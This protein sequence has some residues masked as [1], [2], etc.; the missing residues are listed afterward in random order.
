MKQKPAGSPA[1]AITVDAKRDECEAATM[2][3]VMVGPYLRHGIVANGIIE[4]MAGKLP[5]EPKFEDFA[6]DIKAKADLAS[7]GEMTLASEILAAQALSLDMLFTEL[8]RRATMNLGDY[9]LMAE[10]YAR[11]AFKAQGNCRAS[12]EALA[13][14]HQ[15]REQTVRHVH[16][17]EGGQA[18]IADEFHHHGGQEKNGNFDEQSHATGTAGQGPSLPSPDPH[19]IGVPIAS[20]QRE[21][22]L[23][24]ARRN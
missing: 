18:V 17:N 10:R 15:P 20:G 21:T 11:L 16:V 5:G 19:G 24:D 8:A 22:A 13:K 7:K 14:L 12:L 9:P 1:K 3:R 2:A 23:Q 4:K 6:K